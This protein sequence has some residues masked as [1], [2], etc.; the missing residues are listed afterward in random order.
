M[1]C[2][3]PNGN[4]LYLDPTQMLQ[5]FGSDQQ[6]H[7]FFLIAFVEL[8][9]IN[10]QLK[11]MEMYTGVQNYWKGMMV[12]DKIHLFFIVVT[13]SS[14]DAGLFAELGVQCRRI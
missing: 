10:E 5:R 6:H 3:I 12:N 1:Q 9:H 8:G 4:L 2:A 13:V 14:S 11:I 7:Y